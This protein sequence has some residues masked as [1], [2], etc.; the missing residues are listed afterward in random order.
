MSSLPTRYTKKEL[1]EMKEYTLKNP[2]VF[3]EVPSDFREKAG[4]KHKDNF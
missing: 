4:K 2:P 1:E 3:A